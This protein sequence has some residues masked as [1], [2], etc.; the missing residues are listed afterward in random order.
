MN[1]YRLAEAAKISSITEREELRSAWRRKLSLRLKGKASLRDI[2]IALG[3]QVSLSGIFW[4]DFQEHRKEMKG[5]PS[6]L[7][8]IFTACFYAII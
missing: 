8:K 4:L 1:E 3:I 5:V 6:K 7:T 2:L